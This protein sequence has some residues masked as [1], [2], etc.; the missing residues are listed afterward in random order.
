MGL[1]LTEAKLQ[2]VQGLQGIRLLIDQYEQ[3]CSSAN[4]L[5]M[6]KSLIHNLLHDKGPSVQVVDIERLILNQN[7]SG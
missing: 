2:A 3:R 7:I 1:R 5:I 4:T 6:R